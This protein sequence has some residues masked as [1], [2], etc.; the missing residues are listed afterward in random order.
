M[1]NTAFF[2]SQLFHAAFFLALILSVAFGMVISSYFLGQRRKHGKKELQYE[3]GMNATGSAKARLSI[4]Y[5]LVPIFFL[6]F[7]L[8]TIFIFAWAVSLKAGGWMAYGE[9]TIFIIVLM[10]GLVYIW[11]QG[12]LKTG[13]SNV[14]L[15]RLND[16]AEVN[17]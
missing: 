11:R 12:A 13:P 10:T 3:S 9:M 14:G 15:K 1:V 8:E 5:Y 4:P 6:I 2:S 16:P 7:H 17:R